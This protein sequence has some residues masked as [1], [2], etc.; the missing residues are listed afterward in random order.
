M[1]IFLILDIAVIG[2]TS[3]PNLLALGENAQQVYF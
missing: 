1:L 2:G 3:S